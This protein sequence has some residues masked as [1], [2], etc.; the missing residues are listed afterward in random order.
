MKLIFD[1]AVMYGSIAVRYLF[2]LYMCIMTARETKAVADAQKEDDKDDKK[3]ANDGLGEASKAPKGDKKGAESSVNASNA[4]GAT[5]SVTNSKGASEKRRT[6]DSEPR[7]SARR[8]QSAADTSDSGDYGDSSDSTDSDSSGSY[9]SSSDS[10]T[11]SESDDAAEQKARS[12]SAERSRAEESKDE[13][14]SS[15]VGKAA[16]FRKPVENV[17]YKAFSKA[18]AKADLALRPPTAHAFI[19]LSP[20]LTLAALLESAGLRNYRADFEDY[21]VETVRRSRREVHANTHF[22]YAQ[23]N[24]LCVFFIPSRTI[25]F[26]HF[27]I[28][29]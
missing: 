18:A 3:K 16:G 19:A 5:S 20:D 10:S 22:A 29:L 17:S 26:L 9:E 23:E 6:K 28:P 24:P 1:Y 8:I 25:Y 4:V 21:G 2:Y 11:D 12:S 15:A 14:N 27:S 13:R 7:R